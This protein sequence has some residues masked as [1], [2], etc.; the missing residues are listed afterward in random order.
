MKTTLLTTVAI[1]AMTA[2]TSVVAEGLAIPA[3]PVLSGEVSLDF[4]ETKNNNS[5]SRPR[6][7]R[8]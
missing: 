8:N 1:I 5:N 4:A 3:S 2:A 6:H 7:E